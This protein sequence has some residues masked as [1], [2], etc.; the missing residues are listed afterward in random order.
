[1]SSDA[2]YRV[3]LDDKLYGV[4]SYSDASFVVSELLCK[5]PDFSIFLEVE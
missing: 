1:M 2:R 5:Y 3:Y 4:F